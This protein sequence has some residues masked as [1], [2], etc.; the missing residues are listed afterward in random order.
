M[1]T[2]RMTKCPNCRMKV[3]SDARKAHLHYFH[4][5]IYIHTVQGNFNLCNI[6]ESIF[7]LL[8]SPLGNEISG[9]RPGLRGEIT[10]HGPSCSMKFFDSRKWEQ[11]VNRIHGDPNDDNDSDVVY[12]STPPEEYPKPPPPATEIPAALAPNIRSS[13]KD[14]LESRK[15]LEPSNDITTKSHVDIVDSN[16]PIM[17]VDP[18]NYVANQVHTLPANFRIAVEQH[19]GSTVLEHPLDETFMDLDQDH[20]APPSEGGRSMDLDHNSEDMNIEPHQ[21]I[22]DDTIPSNLDEHPGLS[23]HLDDCTETG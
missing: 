13:F 20:G 16:Q 12:P 9:M 1:S 5:L 18:A 21:E 15:W 22:D 3:P 8:T 7:S 14:Y 6:C 10:C 17:D 19:C 11:H 4:N 23:E 2:R